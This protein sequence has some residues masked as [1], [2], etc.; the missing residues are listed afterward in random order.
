MSA[1]G[2]FLARRYRG[3][4]TVA[5]LVIAYATLYP[6][7]PLRPP[8]EVTLDAFFRPRYVVAFDVAL[9]VLAY[10]PL[11]TLACLFYRQSSATTAAA[12]AKAVGLCVGISLA[13][14]CVQLFV[15]FRVGSVHDVAANAAGAL[16]GA[17]AFAEPFY[18]LVTRPLGAMRERHFIE[19]PWGDSGL[20]LLVL[21]LIAQLNPAL[22]FSGAGH[23]AQEGE[24]MAGLA[25]LQGFAVAMSICGLGL[26]ISVVLRGPQGALRS[27]VVLLSI[28]L[29]LK[30]AAASVM[31]KPHLSAE[32]VNAERVL[33]LA[34]GLA[35]FIP[36]RRM[37]RPARI[38][39]ALLLVLAGALFAKIFGAYGAMRELMRLFT[40]PYGQLA[41]FATLTQLLHE[42][43][44]FLAVAFL[45]ALFLSERRRGVR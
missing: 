5:I 6:L 1:T 18:G 21:W 38:Y 36:L 2:R 3:T 12:M 40:W 29:W 32:W 26:F 30:F 23:I 7:V 27:T 42:S 14:E 19:G 28:A 15:P 39:L 34:V 31:L 25:A 4:L 13:L 22:P 11:G 10:V 43:W 9:N 45:M 44:P 37:P 20:V 35:A 16:A 8:G 24:A 41:N 17:L 33:G